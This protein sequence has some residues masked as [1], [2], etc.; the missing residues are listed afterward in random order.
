[1][2]KPTSSLRNEVVLHWGVDL[3]WEIQAANASWSFKTEFYEQQDPIDPNHLNT[4]LLPKPLPLP[5][6]SH[7]FPSL[8]ISSL[9]TPL[10]RHFV[11]P[12]A[13]CFR[14]GHARCNSRC[15]WNCSRR[16]DV[17]ARR[18]C[19][20]WVTHGHPHWPTGR[21]R[22]KGWTR[23]EWVLEG[24]NQIHQAKSWGSTKEIKKTSWGLT[25]LTG[26]TLPISKLQSN[27]SALYDLYDGKRMA[28]SKLSPAPIF[29]GAAI[30]VGIHLDKNNIKL[31]SAE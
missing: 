1:M 17:S 15:G 21:S 22:W 26:L 4:D 25:G 6:S 23:P 9:S 14:G 2:L 24:I 19:G 13:R 10:K 16:W 7:L 12:P 5:I 28:N 18:R 29:E 11:F 3:T 30:L 8:P 20:Y 27:I 31:C